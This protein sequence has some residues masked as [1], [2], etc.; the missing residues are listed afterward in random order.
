MK[1]RKNSM[2]K[3]RPRRTT[4]EPPAS[5]NLTLRFSPYAWGKLL[6]LRDSGRTE[7]GGF[8]V[9]AADDLL[10]IEDVQLVRQSCTPVTVRFDD[11]SVADYFDTQVDAGLT[12][13]RFARIWVHTH[14]GNSAQ[15]TTVDE[16]TFLRCFGTADWA[17]MFILAKGGE[18]FARLQFN[19]GPGLAMLL[20]VEIDFTRPFPAANHEGW[21]EEYQR[22]VA[23]LLVTNGTNHKDQRGAGSMVHMA[24]DLDLPW[25]WDDPWPGGFERAY[26]DELEG[27][28][29]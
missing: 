11:Q 27:A 15:P 13:E 21:S 12:P 2:T 23:N 19:T 20:E 17:V 14:P 5:T 25:W 28:Y 7:V 24:D 16:E 1:R 3:A 18:S 8:G 22:C 6:Y 9:S 29:A 26:G 4:E 10:R